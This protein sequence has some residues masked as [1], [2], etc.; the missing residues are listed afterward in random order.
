M[1]KKTD[2]RKL[3]PAQ[4]AAA[5]RWDYAE[6]FTGE[7]NLKARTLKSKYQNR[8]PK[9]PKSELGIQGYRKRITNWVRGLIILEEQST[10]S[11]NPNHLVNAQVM[12][13]SLEAELEESM[14][15]GGS[16]VML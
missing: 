11:N 6:E 7:K 1:A 12:S 2:N 15:S 10:H 5:E 13:V 9:V 8:L 16:S 14:N 4:K 3:S